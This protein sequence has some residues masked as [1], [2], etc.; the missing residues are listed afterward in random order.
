M[1]S[2][3]A[4]TGESRARCLR[5]LWQD[6]DERPDLGGAE[7]GRLDGLRDRP[8]RLGN[9]VKPLGRGVIL[10]PRDPAGRE[11]LSPSNLSFLAEGMGLVTWII[12]EPIG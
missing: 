7:D 5:T 10:S 9:G 1:Y 8:D 4:S 2:T 12:R 6:L 11:L 3:I